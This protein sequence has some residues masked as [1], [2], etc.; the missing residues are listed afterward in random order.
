MSD[1]AIGKQRFYY[2]QTVMDYQFASKFNKPAYNNRDVKYKKLCQNTYQLDIMEAL[3][4]LPYLLE[5]H[6]L[7]DPEPDVLQNQAKYPL[8]SFRHTT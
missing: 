4:Q 1:I 5:L 2:D 6:Q 7:P 3:T 8:P